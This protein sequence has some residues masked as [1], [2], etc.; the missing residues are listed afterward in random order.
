MLKMT[1]GVGAVIAT[2][3]T[4]LAANRAAKEADVEE[5]FGQKWDCLHNGTGKALF[6]TLNTGFYG[7]SGLLPNGWDLRFVLSPADIKKATY[8][9]YEYHTNKLVSMHEFAT[10]PQ[11]FP[12]KNC[13]GIAKAAAEKPA[14]HKGGGD[15][16][17]HHLTAS[18]Q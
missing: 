9:A 7:W 18:P 13:L 2:G 12:P 17:G 1:A 6:V 5:S 16:T 3:A 14:R 11:D 15:E 10:L 8:V 4:A